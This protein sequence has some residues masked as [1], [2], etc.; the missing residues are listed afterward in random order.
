MPEF[1]LKTSDYIDHPESKETRKKTVSAV[2]CIPDRLILWS[3]AE[4][5]QG[6][7]IG[8]TTWY[9]LIRKGLAPKPIKVT[10]KRSAW[11]KAEVLAFRESLIAASRAEGVAK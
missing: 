1:N 2:T 8:K 10:P 4:T 6:S 5:L 9:E 3:L 7:C 11:V